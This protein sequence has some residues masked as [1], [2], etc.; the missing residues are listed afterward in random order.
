MA[1]KVDWESGTTLEILDGHMEIAR[2]VWLID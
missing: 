2:L 1:T